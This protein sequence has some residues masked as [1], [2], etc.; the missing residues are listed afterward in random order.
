MLTQLVTSSA[1]WF[2]LVLS[3]NWTMVLY[4]FGSPYTS[5]LHTRIP[6]KTSWNASILAL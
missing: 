5:S 4:H 3:T 6:E 1:K 2:E